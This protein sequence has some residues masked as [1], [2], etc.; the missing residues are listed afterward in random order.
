MLRMKRIPSG[1]VGAMAVLVVA[2][3]AALPAA[4]GEE[5]N[6]SGIVVSEEHAKLGKPYYVLPTK[7]P[8]VSFTSK[9]RAETVRGKS[10]GVTGYVIVPTG[11]ES[12]PA[13]FAAGVFD[14]PVLSLDTGNPTM[15]EHLQAGRWLN[16]S[17]YPNIS[18]RLSEVRDASLVREKGDT[19]MYKGT[20]VGEMTLL[21]VSV[22]VE[23][24]ARITFRPQSKKTRKIGPGNHISI[25]CQYVVPLADFGIGE[26]DPAIK[27]GKVSD[28]I[29]VNIYLTLSDAKPGGSS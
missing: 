12:S 17:A 8:C 10:F 9:A 29:K 25:K 28:K 1:H 22:E 7:R 21:A 20:L 19:R 16:A 18:F 27:S 2:G 3:A 6:P 24:P 11:E 4:R 13:Q 15:N 14:V 5:A 23:I 26:G